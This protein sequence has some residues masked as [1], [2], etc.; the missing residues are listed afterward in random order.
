M[1]ADQLVAIWGRVGVQVC[2]VATTLMEQS[3]TSL[4]ADGSHRGFVDAVLSQ[5]PNAV[6]P[7]S[8][9]SSYGYLIYARD[10]SAVQKRLCEIMP[11]DIVALSDAKLKGHKGIQT[12]HQ[13]VGSSEEVVGIVGEYDHKK[14]KIKVFEANLQVGQQVSGNRAQLSALML[15]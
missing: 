3:K 12:Y 6:S 4:V 8:S 14:S 11:G 9:S 10:G 13:T 15:T 2:E 7:P 5:V 1:S